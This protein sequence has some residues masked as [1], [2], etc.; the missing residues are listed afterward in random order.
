[1][2]KDYRGEPWELESSAP[3]LW[4]DRWLAVNAAEAAEAKRQ[5][6]RME[7]GSSKGRR[8]L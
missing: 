6:K 5:R 3:A 8:L 7:R 4:V 1:M 2:A